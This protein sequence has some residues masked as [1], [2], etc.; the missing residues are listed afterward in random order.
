ML[1]GFQGPILHTKF[2]ALNYLPFKVATEQE[3][4]ASICWLHGANL[5]WRNLP[6]ANILHCTSLQLANM[7]HGAYL[8]IP[9]VLRAY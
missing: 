2:K 8:P 4:P 1:R 7:L 6:I 5:P 9:N 3:P